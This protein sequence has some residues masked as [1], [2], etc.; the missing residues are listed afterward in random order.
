MKRF[1]MLL[2]PL[3]VLALVIANSAATNASY[4]WLYQPKFPDGLRK[5]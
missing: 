2:R 5:Q 1:N 3:A 4:L